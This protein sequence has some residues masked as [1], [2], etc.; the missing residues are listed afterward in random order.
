MTTETTLNAAETMR[1]LRI[2]RETL[3]AMLASGEL[4]GFRRG[5]I[6]RVSR[7]S[8]EELLGRHRESAREQT[9]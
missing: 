3:A 9:G 1:W 2:T 7:Q 8:V 6:I 4:R 5:R